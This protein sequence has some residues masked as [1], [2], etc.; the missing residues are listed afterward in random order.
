MLKGG[1]TDVSP[2][3]SPT[4][5]LGR[6]M[7]DSGAYGE[8]IDWVKQFQWRFRPAE[9]KHRVV[10]GQNKEAW[11]LLLTGPKIRKFGFYIPGRKEMMRPL[12]FFDRFG[13]H[14]CED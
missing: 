7:I 12:R 9:W 11:T 1:Y 2:V 13:H 8:M 10:L 14:P 3:E 6:L 4:D 5:E